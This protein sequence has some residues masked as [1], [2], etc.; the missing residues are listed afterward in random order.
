[1]T[2]TNCRDV[3]DFWKCHVC[4]RADYLFLLVP[5]GPKGT[6]QQHV[7]N[8]FARVERRL[9]PFFLPSGLTKVRGLCLFGY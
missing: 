5:I 6:A 3:Y 7:R 2:V 9:R 8:T 4:S 1:M